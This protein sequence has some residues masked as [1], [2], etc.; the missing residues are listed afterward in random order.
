MA[1]CASARAQEADSLKVEQLY[2]AVVTATAAPK[3]AP[4][5]I[6]K[7]GAT[8]LSEFSRGVQ[9]LPYL[10]T[11]VP[12]VLAW[13]ENG[14][15]TGTTYLRIRGAG[16]SRINVTIDGVPL[17]SPEDQCVFWANMNSYS[18]F[19][20]GVEI[21]RGVGSSSNGDGAFGGTISL[22][23]KAP[24]TTPTG[25]FSLSYGS[26]NS[27]KAGLS[28]S[29]GLLGK[30]WIV[31]LGGY[32]TSTDGWMHG[33]AGRSGSWIAGVTFLASENLMIRYRNIG[34]YEHTGQA[35]NGVDSGDLLDGNYGVSTG[36]FGYKDLYK[37]G[38]GRYNSLCEYYE[39]DADGKYVFTAYPQ[40]TTDN[41]TQDHNILS[42]A[43]QISETWHLNAS[44]HY[45]YG[46]GYYDEYRAS[47]KL[48]KFGLENFVLSDGSTLKKTDFVRKK[49]IDQNAY[50]LV[51]N[52]ARTSDKLDLRLGLSA[53]NFTGWHYGYLT[54]IKNEELRNHL[55]PD[56]SDYLYYD[57]DARKT[58][59]SIFAKATYHINSHLAV[60]GDLQYRF[61]NYV[62]GGYNDKFIST[63]TGIQ[64]HYLDIDQIYNFVNPKAGL[65]YS[66]GA[67]KAFAS[68]AMSHREP[69]RN[70]FTDNG[71]QAA[72]VP[73]RLLDYE[74]GYNYAG[75]IF[76][77]GVTLYYMDY[78]NQFV[79]TGQISDI[80][81]SLTTNMDKSYRMGIELTADI[82]AA[83][84]LDFNFDAAL[85]RN[86]LLDFDEWVED[87]DSGDY[88]K[89][90]H[91]KST[92]AF[93]P[94]AILG[95]GF[96]A[97]HKG[98]RMNWRTSYVSRQYMDNS[99][100]DMRSLPGFSRTDLDLSYTLAPKCR[101]IRDMVF[102]LNLGNLFNAHYASAGWVYSAVSASCGHD[103]DN[104][105]NQIGY[106]P[107][108]GFTLMASY[109]IRF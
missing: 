37:A 76:Q 10:F 65:E 73:E 58:D 62:T 28:A 60:F 61:V 66:A 91:D 53:Q 29:T 33:T 57:S 109:S 25:E 21:Q 46:T 83:K 13:G 18:S 90:H 97:H 80:G 105:Y 39:Q 95:G 71:T 88:V 36:I 4:F 30:R 45:T 22:S 34:N 74:L 5:A 108:A 54:Y 99:Q 85:S 55:S 20:G 70:N 41:F 14:L 50:G 103:L 59:A 68:L 9:E 87:W 78:H 17:N 15:G 63:A 2:E 49:G 48:S 75:K 104:R 98:F 7:I 84:W 43:W 19:L 40:V 64:K 81:E 94:S 44:L 86:C 35:W 42:A 56:G 38:L 47:N 51:V 24:S 101:W 92:I 69:E 23:T 77:G 107:S 26:Y 27:M 12:G 32:H 82:K 8:E 52:A 102:G 67:H 11:H 89:L 100:C 79:Q 6:S 93:S 16:D 31:N 106:I 96:C 72:P 3:D 1:A